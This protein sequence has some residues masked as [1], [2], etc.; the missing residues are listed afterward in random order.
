MSKWYEVT[1]QRP[2]RYLVEVDH[3]K[4]WVDAE[5]R[6]LRESGTGKVERLTPIPKT[7][8]KVA[9]QRCDKLLPL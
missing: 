7:K 1:I 8:F 4:G 2:T 6:A 3:D 9:Q 5:R